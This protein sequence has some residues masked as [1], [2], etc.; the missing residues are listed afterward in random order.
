MAGA[1]AI[2]LAAPG[3]AKAQ[4]GSEG[5]PNLSSIAG[6]I[7]D[8]VAP[9]P[10]AGKTFS[11]GLTVP[12][13]SPG[14]AAKEIGKQLREKTE[15]ASGAKQPALAQ[16]ESEMPKALSKLEAELV[17]IGLAKRDFGIAVGYFFVTSYETATGKTVPVD[18]SLTAGRTIAAATAKQWGANY[19]KL[20]PAKQEEMYE[21]LLISSTLMNAFATQ[22]EQAGKTQEAKGMRDAAGTTFQTLFGVPPSAVTIDA[23]G[24]ISGF[25][26]ARKSTSG[27]AAMKTKK[28]A[29]KAE[30]VVNAGPIPAASLQGAKVFIRYRMSYHNGVEVSLDQ[31]LMFPDGTAFNEVPNDPL[32]RF[33]IPTLKQ[34]LH[35]TDIGT[36]KVNGKQLTLTFDGKSESYKKHPTGGWAEA[37][38]K[39]GSFGVYFPVKIATKQQLL[40]EW[41][42]KS[43]TTMGMAGGGTPMVAAGSNSQLVFTASGTFSKA[44]KSFASVTTANMG[45]AFKTG[46]DVTSNGG[47]SNSSQGRW[48]LDGPLLTTVENGQRRILVA[49]IL[50]K[51][52]K[53]TDAPEI[54]IQGD[55]YFRPGTD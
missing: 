49:F 41:E 21:K 8:A 3:R 25:A 20:E 15:A 27:A 45:D 11:S 53:P 28:V 48:R 30:P 17:K 42:H 10:A 33:D 5:L 19:K 39:D 54:L 35:P 18:A 46:G 2:A 55:R 51:W 7:T 31:L 26:V 9:K 36:W 32:P 4:L 34:A 1:I 23:N 50:P 43:L 16:L 29:T 6:S 40:G 24:K 13:V 14:A 12:S 37:D 38:Y 44:G 47:R 52:G 22:F